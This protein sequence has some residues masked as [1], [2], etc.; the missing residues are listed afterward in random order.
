MIY[1]ARSANLRV[2]IV[3][4]MLSIT[5]ETAAI[6]VVFVFPPNES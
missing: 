5:G 4:S 3:S 6:K 2:E 1:F